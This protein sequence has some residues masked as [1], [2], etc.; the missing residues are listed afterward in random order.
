[1]GCSFERAD[2]ARRRNAGS[3]RDGRQSNERVI[4]KDQRKLTCG[5]GQRVALNRLSSSS[6]T[7]VARFRP[8]LC[9]LRTAR[10]Q[11]LFRSLTLHLCD[12]LNG[13]FLRAIR[14]VC[15]EER[16]TLERGNSGQAI[17]DAA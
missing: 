16:A 6:S 3:R 10:L 15:C 12:I 14:G 5:K 8:L 2:R 17:S 13:A 7:L 9:L 11:R 4:A 1:M